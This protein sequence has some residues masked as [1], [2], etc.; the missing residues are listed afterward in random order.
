M[1]TV[2]KAKVW[3]LVPTQRAKHLPREFSIRRL[4]NCVYAR[5][6]RGMTKVGFEVPKDCTVQEAILLLFQLTPEGTEIYAS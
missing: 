3:A 4:R 1:S 5:E 2:H 6:S